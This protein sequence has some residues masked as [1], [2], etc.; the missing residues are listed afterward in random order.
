MRTI[1]LTQWPPTDRF[2]ALPL[3]AGDVVTVPDV[4]PRHRPPVQLFADAHRELH[5]RVL[6]A[7][8]NL[9]ATAHEFAGDEFKFA[10]TV[11]VSAPLCCVLGD[12]R[13][14]EINRKIP[15]VWAVRS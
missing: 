12:E 10:A 11:K 1:A 3:A 15:A 7:F 13:M 4:C 6:Q 14:T 9:P 8:R 2:Y 5:V